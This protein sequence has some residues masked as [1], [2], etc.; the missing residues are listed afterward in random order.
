MTRV[1]LAPLTLQQL[2][3]G[4]GLPSL[5]VDVIDVLLE[6]TALVQDFGVELVEVVV[7]G[8]LL[9]QYPPG[10]RVQVLSLEVVVVTGL[11][12]LLLSARCAHLNNQIPRYL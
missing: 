1:T 8:V 12:S 5:S 3:V 6:K 10:H 9:L 7:C 4:Q 11:W 2:L